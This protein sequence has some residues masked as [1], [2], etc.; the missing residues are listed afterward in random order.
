MEQR[1]ARKT[2][3]YKPKP[4]P[5]PALAFVVRRCRALCNAAQQER[6]EAW[7]Q[8]RLSVTEAMQSAQLPNIK[9]VRPKYRDI[10]TQ[11]LH[12]SCSS[13]SSV[14]ARRSSGASRVVRRLA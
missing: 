7:E 3:K 12:R 5:Q 10:H 6:K 14:P 8:R 1:T 9:E 13:G 11:V 4:T 2:Y